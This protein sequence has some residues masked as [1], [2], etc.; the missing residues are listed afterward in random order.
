M[1]ILMLATQLLLGWVIN[2]RVRVS[3]QQLQATLDELRRK[4]QE[5]EGFVYIVSHDLRAPLVNVKGFSRE[6]EASCARL[7]Q[8]MASCSSLDEYRRTSAEVLDEEIDGALHYISASA[9]K[10]E[11]LIEALLG[12]SRHGRQQYTLE[13][14]NVWEL[15]TNAVATFEQSITE[16]GAEVEVGSLPAV[17]AD[18]TALCQVF[19][20]LIG[21]CLKYR[22]A[23]R[24]LKIEIGGQVEG[25]A[26]HYWVRD[27]GL[28]IP[29][30]GQARLFQ[31]FQRLHPQQAQG[32]GM[33]LAIAHRIIE[34]HH[35]KIWAESREGEG[36][37]FHFS[38][39]ADPD[40]QRKVFEENS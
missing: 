6:L 28:G 1:G 31:V 9:S 26:V 17:Q 36:S 12:L 10:F 15:V 29:E 40:S 11:R 25:D 35:G 18:A 34:R 24:R 33:G 22:S 16:A 38:L 39:P 37:T 2:R 32:E 13:R 4:N 21:N 5:V 7:K 14:I 27:N 3:T 30:A 19:S 23:D 8:L 20:N